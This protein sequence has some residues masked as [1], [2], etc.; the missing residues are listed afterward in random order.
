MKNKSNLWEIEV[1]IHI[2]LKNK[3][4]LNDIHTLF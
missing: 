2:Y 4:A 3:M 1:E